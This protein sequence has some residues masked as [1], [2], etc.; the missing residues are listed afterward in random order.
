MNQIQTPYVVIAYGT[1]PEAEYFAGKLAHMYER[2][3]ERGIDINWA[4]EYGVHRFVATSQFDSQHR[5]HTSFVNVSAPGDGPT[6]AE[7][8]VLP[9]WGEQI[10]SYIMQPFTNVRDH[11]LDRE[12]PNI[13][14]VFDGDLSFL[15]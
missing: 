5:R 8:G 11:V 9:T 6:G 10:R 3:K 14:A 12:D 1:T 15:G 7:S 2:A 4:H 13:D